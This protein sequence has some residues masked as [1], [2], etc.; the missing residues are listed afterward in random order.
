LKGYLWA[1]DVPIVQ[2]KLW[3]AIRWSFDNP[4]KIDVNNSLQ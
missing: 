1:L 4:D 2:T 3:K